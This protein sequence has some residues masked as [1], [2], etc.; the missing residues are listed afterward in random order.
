MTNLEIKR[1][2]AQIERRL[3]T[4]KQS[5]TDLMLQNL[6]TY[7]YAA[8]AEL[9]RTA[10][11]KGMF[12]DGKAP[13]IHPFSFW[14][15]IMDDVGGPDAF[16]AYRGL[17]PEVEIRQAYSSRRNW[18]GSVESPVTLIRLRAGVID[19]AGNVMPGYKLLD[20]GCIVDAS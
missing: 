1:R 6:R 13:C 9:F 16:E 18:G 2:L 12:S 19:E 14:I 4:A 20:N 8:V 10:E 3:G 7:G 11:E 5:S 15:D 17:V